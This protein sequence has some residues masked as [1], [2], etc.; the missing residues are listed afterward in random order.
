[1]MTL[2]WMIG[3]WLM[4]T[5]V[6]AQDYD[7]IDEYTPGQIVYADSTIARGLLKWNMPANGKVRFKRAPEA[8]AV[9]IRPDEILGFSIAGIEFTKLENV[10]SVSVEFA[11]VGITTKIDRIYA[12]VLHRG[13]FDVY[14]VHIPAYKP[15]NGSMMTVVNYVFAKDDRLICF[16]EG[17]R[18]KDKRYEKA[19]KKLMKFFAGYD[20]IVDR[21]AEYDKRDSC[22][23][24]VEAVANLE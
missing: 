8:D 15:V 13:P 9:K 14:K 1:M 18:M 24:I 4:A 2:R 20:E 10:P 19:K 5:Q 21:I 22:E 3:I 12:R 7:F 17:L 23:P 6:Q 11:L 16:P